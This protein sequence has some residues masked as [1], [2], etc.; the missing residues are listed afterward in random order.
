MRR[1]TARQKKVIDT[2][3]NSQITEENTWEREQSV[4]KGDKNFLDADDIPSEI[5][6]KIEAINDTEIL[7]QEIDRYMNDKSNEIYNKIR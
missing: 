4:F 7:Y 1:L 2:Y 6:A 3:I 5:Y